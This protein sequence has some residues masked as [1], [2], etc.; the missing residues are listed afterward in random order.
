MLKGIIFDFDGVIAESVQVKTDAFAALYASYGADNVSKVV[1]HHEANGG[2]SRFEKIRLY[3]ESFLNRTV[4]KEEITNLASQ[5][6]ELVVEKVIDAPYVPGALEYIQQSYKQY[7]LLISTGTPT[8]EMN[9]IL[10]GRK[11]AHYFTDVFGSPPK[12]IEHLNNIMSIYGMKPNELIFYGDSNADLD[13]ASNANIKFVL[14]RNQH[15]EKLI[16]QFNGNIIDG[17]TELL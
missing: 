17:F 9:K 5:F 1:E 11:I 6:S 4:T 2:M 15:N 14:N 10:S 7:K 3:H 13:A 8:Q 12:K 16:L